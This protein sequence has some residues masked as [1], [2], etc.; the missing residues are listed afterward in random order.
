MTQPRRLSLLRRFLRN[1]Y[2]RGVHRLVWLLGRST[3]VR[4]SGF[5][6]SLSYDLAQ[7]NELYSYYFFC[8]D[9]SLR[10]WANLLQPG[11]VFFD[12]G[13]NI[14]F[15]TTHMAKMVGPE[16][17]VLSFEP[18]PRTRTALVRNVA[19]NALDNVHILPVAVGA[20]SSQAMFLA[21]REH[22]LSRLQNLN[23]DHDGLGDVDAELTVDV[24]AL[25]DIDLDLGGRS[26]AGLKIDIE[27]PEL[28][29]LRGARWLIEAHRPVL[30]V[31]MNPISMRAFGIGLEDMADF[32]DGL[33]YVPFITNRPRG[34]IWRKRDVSMTQL[35]LRAPDARLESD[36]FACHKDHF[37]R[38]MHAWVTRF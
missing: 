37:D 21:G 9:Q 12:I 27:G 17:L 11:E 3:V 16:G 30:Q 35:D 18:N 33:G 7:A 1:T 23:A 32:L 14:G 31:E 10:M 2:V 24:V 36:V 8:D 13:S 20:E 6:V 15:Y 29:A 28:F 26:L 5:G 38:L 22:G 4:P 19:R 25:D 34:L